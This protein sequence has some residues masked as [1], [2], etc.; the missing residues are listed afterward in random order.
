[1]Q[2]EVSLAQAGGSS[3]DFLHQKVEVD[4]GSGGR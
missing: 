2:E 3:V 1:M 4:F